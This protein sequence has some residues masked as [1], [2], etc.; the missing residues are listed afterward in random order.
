MYSRRFVKMTFG[1]AIFLSLFMSACGGSASSTQS[2]NAH[3]PVT[4]TWFMWSGSTAEVNA[5]N[6]DATLVTK[7]YPWIHIKFETTDWNDYW[8]KFQ[9]EAASS[10]LP[11][12]ISLQSGRTA[13]YTSSFLS[14]NDYI[15]NNNFD[16]SSFDPSIIKALTSGGSLRALPYDFG[17]DL[18][19]YN[20][21]LFDKYHV[22]YPAAN[23]T[24]ND[25][26]STAQ[27]LTSGNNYGFIAT[28]YPDGWLPFAASAGANYLTPDGKLDLN[29][30]QLTNAFQNYAK[31]V[32]QYHVS[33]MVTVPQATNTGPLWS[34]GN[35]GMTIDG[36]WSLINYKN[37][38]KFK[39]GIARIPAQSV[40][41]VSL[42][43][44]SGFGISANSQHADD[45]FRAISV[46]TG[47]DAEQYLATQGRA[48]SARTAQQQYW[49]TNAVPGTEEVLSAA[50]K[51]AVPET[52]T[53]NWNEAAT[54]LTQYCLTVMNG[55][56]TAKKVFDNIQTQINNNS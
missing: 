18:V 45:A 10:S 24:Y 49:Y 54:L 7:K 28:S 12:I 40:G 2:N 38:V 39:F 33:P 53:A 29:N 13:G 23:W 14:L 11:D 17:P 56:Q 48:F 51:N 16:I 8:T 43:A 41:S 3:N 50:L 26:L 32:Y 37:T 9:S 4:L 36:P 46:L 52:S 44:G 31:L 27:K 19:F 22:A 20:K 47:P 34:A 21:D 55:Q 15:K 42:V 25:F 35:I 6:Y 1:C 5:W 30:D